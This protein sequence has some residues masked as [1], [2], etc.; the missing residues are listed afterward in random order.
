M[1]TPVSAIMF[2]VEQQMMMAD[3]CR[4]SF[5]NN[6]TTKN[7]LLSGQRDGI[8]SAHLTLIFWNCLAFSDRCFYSIFL[9][10]S[11]VIR[12]FS[13]QHHGTPSCFNKLYFILSMDWIVSQSFFFSTI[14]LGNLNIVGLHSSTLLTVRSP[15]T[16]SMSGLRS[17]KFQNKNKKA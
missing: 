2:A 17:T 11:C 9:Q 15:I 4:E 13:T 12:I 14:M 8:V 10:F 3:D 7:R 16:S 1:T 5:S 6:F